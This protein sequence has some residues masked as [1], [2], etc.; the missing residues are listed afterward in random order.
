[1]LGTAIRTRVSCVWERGRPQPDHKNKIVQINKARAD[2]VMVAPP[3]GL[4]L[5]AVGYPSDPED[6]ARRA[7]LTRNRRA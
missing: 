1:M 5:V 2:E 4:S 3:Q 7:E 6:Y